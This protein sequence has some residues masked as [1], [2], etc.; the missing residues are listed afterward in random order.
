MFKKFFFSKRTV[1]LVLAGAVVLALLGWRVMAVRQAL[2]K[3]D[4][5]PVLKI[6]YCGAEPEELCV[7]SFGRDIDKKFV[8]NL[9]VPEGDFPEFY[10][11][12][13]RTSGEGVY[14]C[15]QN[16]EVPTS[17]YCLGDMVGLLEEMGV[18]LHS[19]EDDAQLAV[20]NFT[21]EAL[22][23][24]SQSLGGSGNQGG[25]PT[26]AVGALTLND[27]EPSS[28]GVLVTPTFVTPGPSY[29]NPSYP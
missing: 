18:S 20:G 15:V 27:E 4:P 2:A 1:F 17:V 6:R 14:E 23:V 25:T 24:F 10:V 12:I 5:Q 19:V 3:P 13:K 26:A 29:P 9:F 7:L 11:T 16:G 28:S 22:M 21:L 8:V